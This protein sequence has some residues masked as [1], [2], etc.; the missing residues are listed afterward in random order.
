M[1]STLM[2]NLV[3]GR[4]NGPVLDATVRIAAKFDAGVIG[5]AACR[6][7]Q[8]VCH[9]FAVPA[10]LFDEDRKEIARHVKASNP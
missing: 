6:P 3:L 10:V 5:F 4:M 9:D 1:T 8:T 7:I 2:V